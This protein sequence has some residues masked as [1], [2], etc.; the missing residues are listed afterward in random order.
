HPSADVFNPSLCI[1]CPSVDGFS[2]SLG[3]FCSLSTITRQLGVD[4]AWEQEKLEATPAIWRPD[5]Y[6]SWTFTSKQT[7][8]YQ[9][10]PRFVRRI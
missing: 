5:P 9:D 10:T 2:P 4:S 7:M 1:A 6:Q 3:G 8:I